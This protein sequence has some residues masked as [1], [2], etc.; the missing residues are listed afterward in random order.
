[1]RALGS[2]VVLPFEPRLSALDRILGGDPVCDVVIT[3]PDGAAD[4]IMTVIEI[5]HDGPLA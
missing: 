1:M 2:E 4:D 3:I 5:T